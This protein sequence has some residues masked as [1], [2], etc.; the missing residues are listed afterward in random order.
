[1]NIVITNFHFCEAIGINHK[2]KKAQ[3]KCSNLPTPSDN[4]HIK[5]S[6]KQL[7]PVSS[8][9]FAWGFFSEFILG[10][11][12]IV[13]FHKFPLTFGRLLKP[14]C[15]KP[16]YIPPKRLFQHVTLHDIKEQ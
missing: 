5:S 16:D 10:C 6:F 3:R 1:M 12:D 7:T 4:S 11:L 15:F 8:R 14:S 13:Q 2:I 9:D